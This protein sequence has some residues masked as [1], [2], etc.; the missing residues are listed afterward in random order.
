MIRLST[1]LLAAACGLAFTAAASAQTLDPVFAGV[2]TLQDL[3]SVP[4]VPANYGGMIY[5]QCGSVWYQSESNG[6]VVSNP[7]PY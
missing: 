7:P 6:Y 1:G 3:G 4:G 5:Q 2:Y